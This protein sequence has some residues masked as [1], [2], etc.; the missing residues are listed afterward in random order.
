MTAMPAVTIETARANC[1][2]FAKEHRLYFE[3]H[4]EVGIG[5]PCVGFSHGHN[6]VD[7]APLNLQTY[8]L[9][10]DMDGAR[11]AAAAPAD[12]YHKHSCL[13]VLVHDDNYDEGIRQLDQWV[14][15]MEA[16][17][18]LEVALFQTGAVGLQALM[19]GVVGTA[20]RYKRGGSNGVVEGGPAPITGAGSG[21]LE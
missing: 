16:G 5:R 4:G 20:I 7:Y 14:R 1:E 15:K 17:G 12:A 2:R 21:P 6:Y 8:E 13:A 18:E 10:P 11:I 3:D 19:S 9:I